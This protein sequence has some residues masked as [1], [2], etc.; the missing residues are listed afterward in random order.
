MN[1]PRTKYTRVSSPYGPACDIGML[2]RK[3]GRVGN[4][5]TYA[6][7]GGRFLETPGRAAG[8]PNAR[9]FRKRIEVMYTNR[10]GPAQPIFPIGFV[11]A[12]RAQGFGKSVFAWYLHCERIHQSGF[13]PKP[14]PM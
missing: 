1:T 4:L 13:Q 3:R 7:Q 2:E 5:Y 6:R 10:G 14:I 9:C 12:A 8:G 11:Q